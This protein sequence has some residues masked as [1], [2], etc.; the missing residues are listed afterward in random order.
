ML[1]HNTSAHWLERPLYMGGANPNAKE[2]KVK[3]AP[4]KKA[5]KKKKK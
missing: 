2:E 4:K 5:A 1:R 3:K